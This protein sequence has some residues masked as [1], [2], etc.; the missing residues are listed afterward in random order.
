M[1][2]PEDDDIYTELAR[3]ILPYGPQ[4]FESDYQSGH[5]YLVDVD[6]E[7]VHVGAA[8]AMGESKI[9]RGHIDDGLIFPPTKEEIDFWSGQ[10]HLRFNSLSIPPYTLIQKVE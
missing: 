9:I 2:L 3:Q 10:E 7:L 5:L 4:K 6:L 8:M 1:G